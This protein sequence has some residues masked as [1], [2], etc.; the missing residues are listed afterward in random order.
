G[1]GGSSGGNGDGEPASAVRFAAAGWAVR[2]AERSDPDA[3]LSAITGAARDRRPTLVCCVQGPGGD[4]ILPVVPGS[5][6]AATAEWAALGHRG[7][8]ARRSWLKRKARHRQEAEFDRAF[9]RGRPPDFAE[10][11]RDGCAAGGSN[12]VD[13][14]GTAGALD[15]MRQGLSL[16]DRLLPELVPLRSGAG[17]ALSP[18]GTMFG[19]AAAIAAGAGAGRGVECGVIEHGMAAL[20]NGL[21]LHG[22]TVPVIQAGL[23]SVDRMRPALRLAALMGQAVI[24]LL[25]DARG[26]NAGTAWQTVE[27][28][29][30]LRAMPNVVLFRP[31]DAAEALACWELAL[32]ER[33]GPS[34][35]AISSDDDGVDPGPEP[36]P[37]AADPDATPLARARNGCA[38]GGYLVEAPPEAG[39]HATLL[40]TGPEV[41]VAIEAARMLRCEGID[42]AVVSLPCWE[43]FAAQPSAYRAAILGGAPRIGIEAASGFGWERWLGPDGSFIG[44]DGF[45][46]AGPVASHPH[47]SGISPGSVVARVRRHPELFSARFPD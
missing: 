35:V 27:Q 42:A 23:I 43:L 8:A 20:G 7:A 25:H 46:A 28:L 26:N 39:R 1:A 9:A 3:L 11:W 2:H 16:L 14:T 47:A 44:L 41:R 4:A 24:Y 12:G 22:G 40:A 31:A 18:P 33:R 36:G 29:A 15:G 32:R 17:T 21:S 38:R 6:P 37:A 34:V 19:G 30:S 5:G 10:H 45:G 13:R